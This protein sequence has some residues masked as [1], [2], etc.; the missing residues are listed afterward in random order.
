MIKNK[1]KNLY[2]ITSLL[3]CFYAS[4]FS[5]SLASDFIL[6]N[7]SGEP[8]VIDIANLNVT[9]GLDVSIGSFSLIPRPYRNEDTKS[10]VI[11]PSA[12]TDSEQVLRVKSGPS[13]ITKTISFRS[14]PKGDVKNSSFPPLEKATGG[15]T[16]TKLSDGRVVLIGGGNSLVSNPSNSLQV[17]NPQNGKVEF[18]KTSG[19]LER[20]T[21]TKPRSQHTATYIGINNKPVGMISGPVEQILVVGGVSNKGKI[22]DSIEI[23]EIRVGSNE[24]VSTLLEK[25]NSKLKT[26]RLFHSASLLPDGRVIIIGGQGKISKNNIGALNSIEIFDPVTQVVSPSSFTLLTPRLLHTVTTLQDGDILITGGFTNETTSKFGFGPA[27]STAE[28]IDGGSFTIKEVGKLVNDT[29][30][31]GHTATLLTNGFVLLSGGSTDFFSGKSEDKVRGLTVGILQF[32]NPNTQTFEIAKDTNDKTLELIT[33][34]FLHSTVLLPSGEVVIVGG[35]N[36]KAGININ[37]TINTPV[38]QIE[39]LDLM[40]SF[41]GGNVQI[42]HKSTLETFIGRVQPT[43]ILVTP[44]NKIDGLLTKDFQDNFVNGGVLISG[45]FTGGKGNLPTRSNELLQ[46]EANRGIDGR[47]IKLEPGAVILGSFLEQFSVALDNFSTIPS[48]V[49][50]PQ[51]INLATENN[52]AVSFVVMTTNNETI[53]L[54]AESPNDGIIVSPSLFQAGDNV[55]ITRR[56]GSVSGEFEIKILPAENGQNFIPAKVKVNIAESSKPFLSTVPGHGISLGTEAGFNSQSL[57]V[58]VLSSDGKSEI[59]T[60]P[61]TS[62]VTATIEDPSIANLGGAGVMS[63]VGNLSTEFMVGA[64][65]PGETNI[66]FSIDFPGVLPVS[67]PLKVSGTPSFS[68]I[69][70]DSNVIT[71][72]LNSGVDLSQISKFNSSSFFLE[73]LMVLPTTSPFSIYVPVNLISSTDLSVNQGLFTIRPIFAPDFG[74]LIPRTL[75]NNI[76]TAFRPSFSEEIP[77]LAGIVSSK[78]E[79]IAVLAYNKELRIL[80]YDLAVNKSIN[81]K[82]EKLSNIESVSDVKLFEKNDKVKVAA[83]RKDSLL[84]LDASN[85]QFESAIKLNGIGHK[86]VL[87]KIDDQDAAVVSLGLNGVDFVF[88]LTGGTRVVNFKL[89]GF[90]NNIDIVQEIGGVAGPFVISYD[91]INTISITHLL[92]VNTVI[93]SIFIG[94]EKVLDIAYAGK[95]KVNDK[96]TDILVAATPRQILLFDLNNRTQIVPGKNLKIRERINDLEVIDGIIYLALGSKGVKAVSIGSLISSDK[97]VNPEVFNLDENKIVFTRENSSEVVKTKSLNSSRLANSKPF[98]LTSGESNDLTV[99]KISP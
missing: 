11:F 28:L 20:A 17:L 92:D 21:L 60:I 4:Y 7:S 32:Y 51:T 56:D 65:K 78:N 72:L 39:V 88:P 22:E 75:L 6:P 19:S 12:I 83:V 23:I 14:T 24:A 5:Y 96:L 9:S 85:G 40:S 87:T 69:P 27:T 47:N 52:F 15:H 29:G 3:L 26:A 33:S 25:N 36:I 13:E 91:E 70:V 81:K 45:G 48:V 99:I 18:L 58:K 66:N 34:R 61:L 82:H 94:G 71:S 64:L 57:R 93:D 54:K 89:G 49:V 63:V 77:R 74:A 1:H 95:Y 80:N 44:K 16:V 46:I 98:L 86:I 10:L 30:V 42:E 97:D 90:T 59:N 43:A 8:V 37:T 50:T 35:L 76:G 55:N 53:L 62:S 2:F 67:I 68:D 79:P 41:P 73:D 84:I 31:G 38:S